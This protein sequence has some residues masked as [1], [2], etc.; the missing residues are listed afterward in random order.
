MATIKDV[1]QEAGLAVSTV[2]RILNNRG[3]ISENAKQRV[4]EAMKK[5]NYQPNEL[6]RSLH[7][8]NSNIIGLIVPHIKHPYFAEVI[9]RIEDQAYKKGYRILLCNSQTL[10]A[11]EEAYIEI[12][13]QNRVAG[14]IMCTGRVST[15]DFQDMGIPLVAWERFIEPGIPVVECDNVQGGMLAAEHLISKGCKKLVHLGTILP[16][17]MPGDLRVDGFRKVCEQKN[18][19]CYEETPSLNNDYMSDNKEEICRI[20]KKYPD[21]DGIFTNNDIV[22]AQTIQVCQ[23]LGKRVPEDVKIVGY[24]DVFWA[25]I[26]TPSITTVKQPLTDMARHAIYTLDLA[27]NGKGVANRTMF[28]V[29]LIE[30]ESTRS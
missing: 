26:N 17:Q 4:E 29:S 19:I 11:R 28:P 14:I 21:V 10:D 3:Y 2:S 30:R 9:S 5:L 13:K 7:R 1:A 25:S 8:K 15:K 27:I 23:Q 6:A 16:V 22:A 12:C 24:D 20:L 18:V